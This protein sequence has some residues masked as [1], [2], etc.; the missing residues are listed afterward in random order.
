MAIQFTLSVFLL[1]L[2]VHGL[3]S[4]QRSK[5][6]GYFLILLSICGLYLVWQ[7]EK[8]NSLAHAFGIGRGADLLLYSWFLTS[9]SIMILLNIK[10]NRLHQELTDLARFIAICNA[11]KPTVSK[12]NLKRIPSVPDN[13]H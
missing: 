4:I 1:A 13:S 2:I 10:V 6:I 7:P 9:S 8:A 12:I 11:K 5:L 3:I